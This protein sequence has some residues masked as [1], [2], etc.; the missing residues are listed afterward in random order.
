MFPLRCFSL[1]MYAPYVYYPH[2]KTYSNMNLI[3]MPFFFLRMCIGGPGWG[4]SLQHT[5]LCAVGSNSE[6]PDEKETQRRTKLQAESY[7]KMNFCKVR[8]ERKHEFG[9]SSV[10]DDDDD[11]R[12][13]M[14]ILQDCSLSL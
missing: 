10:L 13:I 6:L 2:C 8:Y 1:K 4:D 5:C 14:F 12:T 9:H 11:K 7:V 3:F